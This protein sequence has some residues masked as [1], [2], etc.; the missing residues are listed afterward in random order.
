[1]VISVRHEDIPRLSG[2]KLTFGDVPV[3]TV[4]HVVVGVSGQPEYIDNAAVEGALPLAV[5]GNVPSSIT[6]ADRIEPDSRVVDD[7][8][9]LLAPWLDRET[10]ERALYNSGAPAEL[11]LLH[12]TAV[13]DQSGAE[14]VRRVMNRLE[15]WFRLKR[16][17]AN[18]ALWP[19]QGG[20]REYLLLTCFDQLGQAPDW[21]PLTDWLESSDKR[22]VSERAQVE[23]PPGATAERYALA[24]VK[25]YH[26][27]YGVRSAF[28]RFIRELLSDG[29]RANLLS[30]LSATR[31]PL[32]FGTGDAR[33]L[34]D[35]KKEEMLFEMRNAFTHRGISRTHLDPHPSDAGERDETT[36]YH[37]GSRIER[38]H[39]L[40]WGVRNW[41]R[42][43][44]E[45]VLAGLVNYILRLA[46]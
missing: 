13:R 17:E 24:L 37:M 8:A 46:A 33:P 7:A 29:Q 3:G 32:P 11:K 19:Y 1:M 4:L 5:V 31:N 44:E 10:V 2:G 6:L 21:L 23:L 38:N 30:S 28:R 16:P 42:V 35:S 26:R 12:T 9:R 22:V 20:L 40:S 41:P 34:P 39:V 14:V 43:L 45:T 36:V 15:L 27:R 25:T 18:R